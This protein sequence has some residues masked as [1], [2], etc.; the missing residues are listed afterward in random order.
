[1]IVTNYSFKNFI[2]RN[3]PLALFCL[4]HAVIVLWVFR[5]SAIY[6]K[7]S[8][9]QSGIGTSEFDYASK[10]AGGLLPYRD[11]SVEYPPVTMIFVILPGLFVSGLG[12]YIWVYTLEVLFF[13]LV[14]LFLLRSLSRE[15]G[16]NPWK[17]LGIYSLAFL[18]VG[19]ILVTRLDFI[20]AIITLL[21]IFFFVKRHHKTAWALLAVA[22]LTKVY[23]VV[24][25]PV[26]FLIQI[27]RKQRG[28]LLGGLVVFIITAVIIAAPF[29]LMS[30]NGLRDSFFFHA[31]RPLQIESTY[32]SVIELFYA[33]NFVSLD[34][35]NSYNSLCVTGPVPDMLA[36]ISFGVT[37]V[38]LLAVYWSLLTILKK[39]H[40]KDLPGLDG[41]R[42]SHLADENA[43]AIR[44]CLLS[45]L[46]FILTCKVFSP[47]YIIW[48]LPLIPLI[49]QKQQNTVWMLFVIAGVMTFFIYPQY[50]DGIQDGSL[51]TI[52]VLVIRN[53]TLIGM[54]FLLL[55]EP[56]SQTGPKTSKP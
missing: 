56:L 23:P 48:L 10:F 55:R 49:Q 50:Y 8:V 36:K 45:V 5:S 29:L 37:V 32:A 43:F 47:Q 1:M 40:L 22:V 38:S 42:P 25:A 9:L 53:L 16:Y 11:F 26:F 19:P 27:N 46:V 33:F 6:D 12:A 13:N 4:V 54:A 31:L 44:Y 35:T 3:W 17:T 20:P 51:I 52:S 39:E 28:E 2:I 15:L 7:L 21:S 14:T 30:E 41:L 24:I 34:F 18:A